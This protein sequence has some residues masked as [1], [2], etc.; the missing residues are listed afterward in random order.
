MPDELR[1]LHNYISLLIYSLRTG[2]RTELR[3][4]TITHR[5]FTFFALARN[6]PFLVILV[7]LVTP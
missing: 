5:I 3:N 7:I 1:V 2:I 6:S 4:S